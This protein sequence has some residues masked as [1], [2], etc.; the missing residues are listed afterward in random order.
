MIIVVIIILQILVFNADDE[1]GGREVSD[2]LQAA[3]EEE[4]P[5]EMEP[6]DFQEVLEKNENP[7]VFGETP[8]NSD[9]GFTKF[10]FT[11]LLLEIFFY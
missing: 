7:I 9:S 4:I 2:V 11:K 5:V 10:I 3:N 6:E 8:S 1:D